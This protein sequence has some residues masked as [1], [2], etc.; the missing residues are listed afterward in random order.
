MWCST[1]LVNGHDVVFSQRQPAQRCS[2]N[3]LMLFDLT[4][5]RRFLP[6]SAGV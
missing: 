1:I 5:K 2:H 4:L 3:F 6:Q